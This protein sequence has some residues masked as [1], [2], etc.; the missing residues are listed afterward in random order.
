MLNCQVRL[1]NEIEM[2]LDDHYKKIQYLKQIKEYLSEVYGTKDVNSKP[3]MRLKNRLDG[4][5]EAGL[6]VGLVSRDELQE[7]IDAEHMTV[8]GMTRKQRRAESKLTTEETEV[9][10][11]FYDTPA[12]SRK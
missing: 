11:G 12:I 10:W 9:D 7:I 3:Y 2:T 4:F 1:V 6:I 5:I 8:F